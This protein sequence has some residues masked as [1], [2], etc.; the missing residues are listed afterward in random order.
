MVSA[1]MCE[2]VGSMPITTKQNKIKTGEINTMSEVQLITLSAGHTLSLHD[3]PTE[4]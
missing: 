3:T 4:L 1:N 2:V